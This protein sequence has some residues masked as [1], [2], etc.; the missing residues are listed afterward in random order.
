MKKALI[1]IC[2]VLAVIFIVVW[3][4]DANVGSDN[5]D[6]KGYVIDVYEN[7][8]GETEIIALSG[9][10]E[11]H[12]VIKPYTKMT[13]PAQKPVEAGDL[14]MLTTTRS[15]SEDIKKMKVSPGYS[16]EGK[17]FFVDGVDSPFILTLST[18]T[19]ARQIV[20][21][22]YNDDIFL[23]DITGIGDVIKIFHSS[24]LTLSDTT[25]VVDAEIF[26]EN[27]SINDLT[28]DDIAFI[29][30]QGYTLRTK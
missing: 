9:D 29:G 1:W 20:N 11:S 18:D 30:S 19:G 12:F 13:S 22:V 14:I 26:I 15:S 17:I 8:K 6:Y 10:V 27:G 5:Y 25:V 7:A 16:T 28:A 3:L 23:P 24:P 2:A 21:L 4:A